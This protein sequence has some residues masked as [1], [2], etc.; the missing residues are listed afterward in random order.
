MILFVGQVARDMRERE[1]FQELDYRAV[2]GTMAKWATEIDDPARIPE[3]VSRAFYTAD[4]RPARPGGDRAARGHADRARRGRRTRRP[5]EPVETWPGLDRHGAAAEAAVGGEAADRAARRQPLVGGRLR[6]GRALRRALRAAGRH[7]VPPRA[8]VR[9]AAPVLRRRPRHRPQPEAARAR[10]G[11]R[12]DRAGRRPARRDA[13]AGLHAA[14][15]SGAAADAS[16]MSIPAPR[17]SAASIARILRS[18]PRRPRS[19]PRSKACS[20][21]TTSRWRDADQGRARRLPRLDREADAAARARVN[22]GEI[23]VWLRDKLPADAIIT[24]G[25]GNFSAWVHRFYRFRRFGTQHRADLG[26]DGLRRA[27][28]G[29]HEAALSRAHGG[30]LRR[31]RR[32]PD[33]RP[34]VRHRRA[35][36]SAGHHRAD[37]RQRHVRHHPHAPGARISR[38][39]GRR[40]SCRTRTSPPMRAPSAASARRWRRPRISP[41][42]F[43]AA[44]K[45]GKPAIIHLKVD[46]EAITPAM[47]LS[48][49]RDKALAEK[50]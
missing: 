32:L 37:R 50:H 8:S 9:P 11:G 45:S 1:A 33:E 24:N 21:R 26:L 46:P 25:A 17:S 16:C 10:Q 19:P 40:P 41:P 20:R 22:F 6:G 23:V 27:G 5:F 47:T 44:Q 49:I 2:F 42:A 3:I 14:R 4:Q 48:A 39:R 38:P 12:P 43:E 29:R 30:L 13:V 15:H 35:V 7:H 36:R 18:T 31:R 28:G 34:G